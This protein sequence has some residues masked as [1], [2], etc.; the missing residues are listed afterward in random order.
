MDDAA[1]RDFDAWLRDIS[2]VFADDRALRRRFVR[3]ARARF[4]MEILEPKFDRLSEKLAGE[5]RF[6]IARLWFNTLR[7]PSAIEFFREVF[8]SYAEDDPAWKNL[9]E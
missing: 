9:V 6:T 4:E 2:A 8:A 5:D 7:C 1:L 3:E